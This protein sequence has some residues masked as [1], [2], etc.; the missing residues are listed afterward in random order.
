MDKKTYKEAW[1]YNKEVFDRLKNELKDTFEVC[2]ITRKEMIEV[3][4]TM[5][6]CRTLESKGNLR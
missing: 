6:H 1:D 4:T 2:G 3:V 5:A